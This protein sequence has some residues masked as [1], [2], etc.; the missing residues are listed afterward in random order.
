MSVESLGILVAIWWLIH[1]LIY[2]RYWYSRRSRSGP[3][4]DAYRAYLRSPEWRY[5]KYLVSLRSGGWCEWCGSRP[6]RQTHHLS[7]RNLGHEP[8]EDLVDLCMGCHC[9]AHGQRRD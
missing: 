3:W 1:C 9:K 5:R 4:W 8:L 2:D 7:Y 6:A